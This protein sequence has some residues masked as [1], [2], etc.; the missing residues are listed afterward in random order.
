VERQGLEP[1]ELRAG[2]TIKLEPGLE[3]EVLNP[4]PGLTPAYVSRN[5]NNS[6]LVVRLRY[7]EVSFLLTADIESATEASLIRGNGL[8]ESTV[9]KVP[10]HGSLTSTT[11]SFLREVR[12]SAAVISV[13]E[14]N[15][16]GHPRP[17]VLD[18]LEQAV[19]SAGLFRTDVDGQVEFIS[20]GR[21]LWVR[22][23][24]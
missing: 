22:T 16:F 20:D 18:R 3:L 11:N 13:G 9:L 21:R 23:Q 8:L 10:H 19:D 14:S 5:E 24:R 6:S 7:N 4:P 15:P 1:I 17:E 2:D 12:P